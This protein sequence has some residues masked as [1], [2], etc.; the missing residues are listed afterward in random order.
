MRNDSTAALGVC[1]HEAAY[2]AVLF[3]RYGRLLAGGYLEE[4]GILGHE[5]AC[6]LAEGPY[7]PELSTPLSFKA[8]VLEVW[9]RRMQSAWDRSNPMTAWKALQ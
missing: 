4:T 2:E 9:C 7:P 1:I 6:R 5:S 8:L 3:D